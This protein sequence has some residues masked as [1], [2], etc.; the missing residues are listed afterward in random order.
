MK[1]AAIYARVSSE[2]QAQKA[3]VHSQIEALK[4]RVAADGCVVLPEHV[5]VD[6]GVSGSTLIRPALE[7]L[8]DRIAEGAIERLRP[9]SRPAG[10]QVRLSG[11]A[12]RRV[13][14][15]WR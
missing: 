13:S 12:P 2:Q 8:R 1:M 3:T 15:T 9:Q 10:A 4:Q 7:R 11:A 14:R 6:D 5:Y